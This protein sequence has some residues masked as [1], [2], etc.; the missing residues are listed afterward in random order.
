MLAAY[1]LQ[2]ATGKSIFLFVSR[3]YKKP[4]NLVLEMH[5]TLQANS[6]VTRQLYIPL[7]R[8]LGL[9]SHD[10]ALPGVLFHKFS[11]DILNWNC[12]QIWKRTRMFLSMT[13]QCRILHKGPCTYVAL[14][15]PFA[16]VNQDML[17]QTSVP[18]K[19]LIAGRTCKRFDTLMNSHV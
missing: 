17:L 5:G 7:A 10:L 4:N 3:S 14:V 9:H 2:S 15:D 18:D 16:R 11:N 8:G 19:G 1:N 13:Y 6:S 12:G